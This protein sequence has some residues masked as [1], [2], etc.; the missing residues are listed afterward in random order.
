MIMDMKTRSSILKRLIKERDNENKTPVTPRENLKLR[1]KEFLFDFFLHKDLLDVNTEAVLLDFIDDLKLNYFDYQNG[2]NNPTQVM[3]YNVANETI[4][5][6]Y[7][8]F[9]SDVLS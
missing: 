3:S 5:Y 8:I 4:N 7:K 2:Y 1:F 9:L 6:M